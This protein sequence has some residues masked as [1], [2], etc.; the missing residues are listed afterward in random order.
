MNTLREKVKTNLTVPNIN[1]SQATSTSQSSLS[2]ADTCSK[3]DVTANDISTSSHEPSC[4][5]S[6]VST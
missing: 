6:K 4:I 5:Q 3:E 2:S 1:G